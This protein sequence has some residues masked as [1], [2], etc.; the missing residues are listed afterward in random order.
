MPSIISRLQLPCQKAMEPIQKTNRNWLYTLEVHR[1]V[2][3]KKYLFNRGPCPLYPQ[4]NS[5][6]DK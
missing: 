1:K 6:I 4:K 5:Q 2:P 3:S